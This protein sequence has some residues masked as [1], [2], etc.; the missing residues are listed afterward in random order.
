MQRRLIQSI[1]ALTGAVALGAGLTGPAEA[2]N[3]GGDLLLRDLIT[4][5]DGSINSGVEAGSGFRVASDGTTIR[6]ILWSGTES[7]DSFLV[8]LFRP[9]DSVPF[10]TLTGNISS[11]VEPVQIYDESIVVDLSFYT[12]SLDS[13]LS[14]ESGDYVLSIQNQ[15]DW[16]WSRII[17]GTTLFRYDATDVWED[18]AWSSGALDLRFASNPEPHPPEPIPEPA[19]LLGLMG[20]GITALRH[21][22]GKEAATEA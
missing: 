10:A 18:A 6:Q 13:P 17:G 11:F 8:H 2:A 1:F 12:L 19:L 14:L 20:L 3:L 4:F 16:G 22:Q 9:E 21:Q 7:T 15:S 5:A